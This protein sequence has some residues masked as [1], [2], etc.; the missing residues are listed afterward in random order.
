M[1][2]TQEIKAQ[3]DSLIDEAAERREDYT[4]MGSWLPH[5]KDVARLGHLCGKL[6]VATCYTDASRPEEWEPADGD[7]DALEEL[8]GQ[9][10]YEEGDGFGDGVYETFD[11]AYKAGVSKTVEGRRKISEA[12]DD[13]ND[14]I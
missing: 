1:N 9:D 3:I 2:N 13:L 8:F 6:A 14:V 4:G 10:P 12:C 7:I 11:R 5:Q